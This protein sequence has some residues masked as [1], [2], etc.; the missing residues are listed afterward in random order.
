[1]GGC[2]DRPT[3]PTRWRGTI[4]GGHQPTSLDGGEGPRW[5]GGRDNGDGGGERQDQTMLNSVDRVS[6]VPG[7]HPIG[8]ETRAAMVPLPNVVVVD[9]RKHLNVPR[10]G[11]IS[12]GILIKVIY[13]P[14]ISGP[15]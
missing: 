3:S 2:E 10:S 1:M 14:F 12:I 11:E 8:W 13:L 7:N 9:D 15:P 5:G 4:L 6:A